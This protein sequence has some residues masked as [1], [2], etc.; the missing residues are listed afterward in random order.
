MAEPN[1]QFRRHCQVLLDSLEEHLNLLGY[2]PDSYR[3]SPQQRCLEW[4]AVLPELHANPDFDN[5]NE[6]CQSKAAPAM[7]NS[8][9]HTR[10][11]LDE[12]E[13]A[14]AR[15]IVEIHLHCFGETRGCIT[16]QSVEEFCLPGTTRCRTTGGA[17]PESFQVL[18]NYGVSFRCTDRALEYL[19]PSAKDFFLAVKHPD[20]LEEFLVKEAEQNQDILIILKMKS[21]DIYG[22]RSFDFTTMSH[23]LLIDCLP[24]LETAEE[25]ELA[26]E[27]GFMEALKNETVNVLSSPAGQEYACFVIANQ[28]SFI[29]DLEMKKR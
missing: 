10:I 6:Q 1:Y 19:S 11:L 7:A 3:G 29:Y 2:G 21:V 12:V 4:S 17:R 23:V 25:K 8:R 5:S 24:T 26:R 20:D 9:I 13:A 15:F 27:F 18:L 14:N 28:F 16:F 22:Q